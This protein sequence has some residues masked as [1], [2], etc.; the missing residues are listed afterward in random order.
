[1][2]RHYLPENQGMLF[3]YNHPRKIRM[4]MKNTKIPLD[5]IW[6]SEKKTIQH[7]EKETTPLSKTILTAPSPI[8]SNY[9]LEINAGLTTSNNIRI[10]DRVEF[11]YQK[12]NSES[13]V[14][15]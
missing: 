10:G 8:K 3:I 7:I 5:I 13:T 15:L 9:I 12:N 2:H 14:V 6:I 4:W 11:I 1:M